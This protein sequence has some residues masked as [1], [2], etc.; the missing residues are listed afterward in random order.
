MVAVYGVECEPV[1]SFRVGG[2]FDSRFG[3]VDGRLLLSCAGDANAVAY[4]GRGVLALDADSDDAVVPFGGSMLRLVEDLG[5]AWALVIRFPVLG[6]T[7]DVNNAG[8]INVLDAGLRATGMLCDESANSSMSVNG[9]SHGVNGNHGHGCSDANHDNGGADGSRDSVAGVLFRRIDDSDDSTDVFTGGDGTRYYPVSF[10]FDFDSR[11]PGLLYSVGG[12]CMIADGFPCSAPCGYK[13]KYSLSRHTHNPTGYRVYANSGFTRFIVEQR[14]FGDM[15]EHHFT[16]CYSEQYCRRV[17]ASLLRGLSV[18][19]GPLDYGGLLREVNSWGVCL[20]DGARPMLSALIQDCVSGL[21]GFYATERDDST[22]HNDTVD[23]DNNSSVANR[24]R[25]P[26]NDA[27]DVIWEPSSRVLP[28]NIERE[29]LLL[30]FPALSDDMVTRDVCSTLAFN[31]DNRR[32]TVSM[33]VSIKGYRR[34]NHCELCM[35][36]R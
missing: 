9:Y 19:V 25:C 15:I 5:K 31:R 28:S 16:S 26:V 11:C 32:F 27:S 18:M 12:D 7:R 30:R 8:I 20:I 6:S 22:Q 1:Y 17:N 24:D 2:L 35:H 14:C 29:E 33:P 3:A 4:G 13:N 36:Q 21:A 23:A 10:R 34:Y